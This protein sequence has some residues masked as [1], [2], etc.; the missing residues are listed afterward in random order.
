MWVNVIFVTKQ[1]CGFV[2]QKPSFKFYPFQAPESYVWLPKS[3][4]EAR[5]CMHGNEIL[6]SKEKFFTSI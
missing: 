6:K 4:S 1:L 5:C 2:S 3:P